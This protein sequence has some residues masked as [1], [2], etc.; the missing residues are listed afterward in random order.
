MQNDKKNM[1]IDSISAKIVDNL[2][3]SVVIFDKDGTSIYKNAAATAFFELSTNDHNPPSNEAINILREAISKPE[4]VENITDGH[5]YIDNEALD[6]RLIRSEVGVENYSAIVV[7]AKDK[8]NDSNEVTMY[9]KELIHEAKSP[10]DIIRAH[11]VAGKELLDPESK[12]LAEYLD[13][14]IDEAEKAGV[15]LIDFNKN[16]INSKINLSLCR[17][18]A[19][20]NNISKKLAPEFEKKNVELCE[21]LDPKLIGVCIDEQKISRVLINLLKNALVAVKPGGIV[22]VITEL[23]ESLRIT[24][25]DNGRGIAKED[26]DK[27][28]DPFFSRSPSGSG[29]GLYI[30]KKIITGHGGNIYV[31]RNYANGTEVV[32]TLPIK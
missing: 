17:I 32:V 27:V 3:E 23:G 4:I 31:S 18:N 19:I 25:R 26:I 29:L 6:Y 20:I 21:A 13:I 22:E 10:L 8:K 28:F 1:L 2:R 5:I 11:A 14:I 15:F 30:C 16:I 12:E 7:D 9:Y 24:V